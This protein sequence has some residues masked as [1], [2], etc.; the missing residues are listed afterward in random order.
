M[1]KKE[2]HERRHRMSVPR[3]FIGISILSLQG[4]GCVGD[5]E[6][7]APLSDSKSKLQTSGSVALQA[8]NGMYLVAEGGAG[9]PVRA[10]QLSIAPWETFTLI[11]LG[12]GGVALQACSG[13]HWSAEGGGG[14]PVN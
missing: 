5:P 11:D 3:V 12:G 6:P 14:G 7:S 9:G 4:F 2:K 10:N 1:S 13:M 8:S